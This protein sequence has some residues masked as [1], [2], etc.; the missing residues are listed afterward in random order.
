MIETKE[1]MKSKKIKKE[2][3]VSDKTCQGRRKHERNE[4]ETNNYN[5]RDKCGRRRRIHYKQK[6][7][8]R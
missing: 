6:Q 5:T 4:E 1:L 3:K 8:N 7:E 2:I